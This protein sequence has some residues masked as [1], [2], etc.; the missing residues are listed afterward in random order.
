VLSLDQGSTAWL[1][2][3]LPGNSMPDTQFNGIDEPSHVILPFF[4]DQAILPNGRDGIWY[5]QD[6]SVLMIEWRTSRRSAPFDSYDYLVWYFFDSPNYWN[7]WY[8]DVDSALIPTIGVQADTN[9]SE[10]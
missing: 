7:F 10:L 9:S 2:F 3:P 6:S 1:N 4:V 8:Y 5:Y